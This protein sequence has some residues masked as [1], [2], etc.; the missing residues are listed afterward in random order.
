[1]ALGLSLVLLVLDCLLGLA[2][3]L[4]LWLACSLALLNVSYMLCLSKGLSQ[5]PGASV[6]LLYSRSRFRKPEHLQLRILNEH[7][8][9]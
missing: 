8:L 7:Q 6:D 2:W 9:S 1:M 4:E 5:N 3:D